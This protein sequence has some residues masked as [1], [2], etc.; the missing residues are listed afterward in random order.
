MDH[1]QLLLGLD[2]PMRGNGNSANKSSTLNYKKLINKIQNKIQKL[3]KCHF[4][5]LLFFLIIS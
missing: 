4:T 2:S 3:N 1:N 5:V